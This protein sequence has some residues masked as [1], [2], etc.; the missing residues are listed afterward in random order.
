M[1]RILFPFVLKELTSW[2]AL[3]LAGFRVLL[4]VFVSAPFG[5]GK[6]CLAFNPNY[7]F[8]FYISFS[9]SCAWSRMGLSKNM[10]SRIWVQ[11]NHTKLDTRLYYGGSRA[12]FSFS[13]PPS[14]FSLFFFSSS[15][16][17]RIKL[18]GGSWGRVLPYLQR[19]NFLRFAWQ[20][21]MWCEVT[22]PR[23]RNPL[24]LKPVLEKVW[25]GS[26]RTGS[27]PV[28]RASVPCCRQVRL[29][30]QAA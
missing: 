10:I 2:L 13:F 16:Y 24:P 7:M 12:S 5:P 8:S 1:G 3:P 21:R 4:M 30:I 25:L 9:F 15:Y 23:F 26:S 17:Q 6:A 28:S 11:S 19:M 20:D 27:R 14:L 29:G 18:P 22:F